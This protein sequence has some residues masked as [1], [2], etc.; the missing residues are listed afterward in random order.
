MNLISIIHACF[1]SSCQCHLETCCM[2]DRLT[3]TK[4]DDHSCRSKGEKKNDFSRHASPLQFFSQ[5]KHNEINE[6]IKIP[7]PTSK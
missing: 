5:T 7:S 1:I 2:T 3:E 6:D 4:A